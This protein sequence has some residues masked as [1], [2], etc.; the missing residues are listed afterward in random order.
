MVCSAFV[1]LCSEQVP[2]AVSACRA[3][4][5]A[6]LGGCERLI[7]GLPAGLRPDCATF[8]RKEERRLCMTPPGAADL[9]PDPPPRWP[10][11][12]S[13][14]LCP[15]GAARS[16]A[17]DCV[18]ETA[19]CERD[20]S[21]WTVALACLSL[22]STSLALL[23]FCAEPARYRYPERPGVWVAACHAVVALAHLARAS[24]QSGRT[25]DVTGVEGDSLPPACVAFFVV[26]YYFSV[27]ADAWAACASAAWYLTAASEWST[28][29]LERAAA[30]LHAAAWGWAGAWTAAALALRRVSRGS[31]GVA[32]GGGALV[33]VPRGAALLLAVCAG[34][35]AAPGVARVVRAVGGA[36]ARRVKLLAA[37]CAAAG[38]LYAALS[39][40]GAAARVAGGEG[41]DTPLLL[42]AGAAAGAWAW[43]RKSAAV[44]RRA[45][46]PPR[47]SARCPPPA[48]LLR[49]HH[50]L[51]KR[52]PV[53]RV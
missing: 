26:T 49:P 3:L 38:A 40:G 22:A 30:Y 2:G 41:A 12:E 6:V 43:S 27:A 52:P 9:E 11:I 35:A 25:C 5:D 24:L 28:E 29:A 14:R 1:P 37:R 15:P 53:S 4:C 8:P 18:P 48:P 34:V 23:T 46:C 51:H 17:G 16:P 42:C 7:A 21:P 33:G 32:G 19:E 13:E 47:K 45:L 20:S 36:G 50:P 31:C 39:A 10:F 44:W